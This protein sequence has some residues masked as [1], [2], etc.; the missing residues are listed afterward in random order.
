MQV[1]YAAKPAV[2]ITRNGTSRT[3]EAHEVKNFYFANT[4]II[5]IFVSK[6]TI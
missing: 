5:A 4:C 6:Y 1:N 3:Q 2:Y